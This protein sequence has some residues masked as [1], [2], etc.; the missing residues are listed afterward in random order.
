MAPR[1]AKGE[2]QGAGRSI[3]TCTKQATGHID[4]VG[5]MLFGMLSVFSEF[6]RQ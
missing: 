5:R 1:G 4:A 2:A 3:S 6:E